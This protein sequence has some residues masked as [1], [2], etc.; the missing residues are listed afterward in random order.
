MLRQYACAGGEQHFF[1][2]PFFKKLSEILI[3]LMLIAPAGADDGHGGSFREMPLNFCHFGFPEYEVKCYFLVGSEGHSD[4]E[5]EGHGYRFKFKGRKAVGDIIGRSVSQNGWTIA[6]ISRI[7]PPPGSTASFASSS[8][9]VSEGGGTRNVQVNLSPAPQSAIT[10]TYTVGGSATRNTDYTTSGSVSVSSGATSVNIP[11]VITDD[12]DNENNETVLLT[13]NNGTGYTVGSPNSHTLTIQDNDPDPSGPTAS[14]AS[15]SGSVGEGGG[16][17]NVQ[18]N[19]SPAPQSTITVTYTVGG[20]ATRNTDYTTSG[21]VSVS[22]GATSVNIPVVITDDN[23]NENNETV[24][25]TLNNG[26]GYTVGSPNSHTLTI[27]DNDPDPSGPTASFASSSGS[28]GEGGGTRNVQVNLSPA[29]QST[30]TVTYTVGGSATHNTDYTT[31]GSVS[32]SS[33]ATSVNIPVVITDDNDNENNET[34]LLTLNNGTGYTVGSP[35]SHTLTIQD[36]DPDP[37]GPTASFASSS[38]SVSEG[39]GTRNVQVNLSPAPQ[40]AIIVTY[41]VG[42]SATRNTDYTTSGSVSVS[43]GA[44][45]VNIP[46]VITDDNDNENNET[47]LLTLNNGTGYTVGSPNSHTLTIQDNDND[48]DDNDNTNTDDNDNTN[49]DDNDNTNTDDNDNTNTDDNDNTNT[50]DNDNTNTDDNDNTNTD[51]NDNSPST[52]PDVTFVTP[53]VF[54]ASSSASVSEG[55]GTRNVQVNLSPA[56]QSAITVSYMIDGTATRGTDY[57]ISDFVS[58][59]SGATSVN[60]PVTITV[61]NIDENDET[62]VLMLTISSNYTLGNIE[63]H[64]LTIINDD[65]QPVLSIADVR[66]DE[67]DTAVFPVRLSSPSGKDVRVD[68]EISGGTATGDTDYTATSGT[69]HIPAGETQG[70]IEVKT[71]Q[72]M[73]DEDDKTIIVTLSNPVHATLEDGEAIGT[74]TDDD[75]QPVLSIADV[76]VD[77]GDT[78]VFPVQLS[79]PS[80]KD[81]RVDWEI[82]GGTATDDTDYTATS[83]T[84]H[85]PA[86]ETQG[87]VEVKTVQDM[88]DEDDKTIVVTLSNPVHATLEDGEAIGTITDDDVQPVLSIA[89]V[90]VDEGDTAVFPVRLS[91]PSGKDVRVDWEI[92]GGTATGDTDYTATS[93]TLHIPAGETQGTVEVKTVQDMLDEDDKTI[94]VTLSNPVHAT[95]EDGEAIGTIVDDDAQPALNI[96]DVRVDEGDTAVFP[97]RLSSPSGKDVR[98]DWEISG[99]TATGDTD[100]TATSGTLHIPAGETQGTVEVKTVQDELDEDDKTIV[101]TLSN[102][103]HATLEDGEAIG[104]IT[105]DDAQP[106]L[107]I[108]DVRVD[109]GDTAVFPVRL[110]S[111]SG[112]DVRVDWEISGGTATGDTDYTATSGTLHIPA[113]ETQGT[114]EVKTVQDMLDED[115]KTIVVTLSNP[116]H[117]TLEDGEAI[118]TIVDDDV[119]PVLNI[120]DVRVDEGDTAVFPVRLSS[121]SGKDVRVDWEI[122]GGTA[123]GDTDYTATSG[124][125]HIPAGETQGTVEVKTV[126]DEL[127]EDDKTIVVTLSNPVHATLEDGEAIGTITDD[128]VQPALSVA[129]TRVNEGDT[130]VFPVR[131][132]SPSGKDVRVDWEISGGTATGDTDYTA[133]SGTLHIPA[134][135]TQGTIE[136]KT[137]QDMLDE[138]DKTIVVT[139]SNPVHATLEDGEAIGTIVD[140][141]VQPALNIA[142]VRVDEGDT[143]VFPVRLSSPSGKDVRVDW[144][145]SGGT[146]TGDTDYT[147]TSGTLHIPAG[148]TQG[149]IEI[150]TVQDMLD[151]DDKTIVVTLSNPVHATLED[152]E[153][154]GTITDDDVQPALNIADVRVDEGDTAVFPV[155]LSSPS[156]KDVRVDWEISGGTATGD[157]DYTAT[158]GTLHIPAGET[159]GTVEVKT[160]QDMLDEDDKTIVVTLS[161]P[162]HATLEDGEAIG[163]ITDDDAEPILTVESVTVDEGATAVFRMYLSAESAKQVTANWT[164]DDAT[165]TAGADYMA[166]SG[167]LS[168]APGQTEQMVSVITIDDNEVETE[169]TFAVRLSN[170]S[171]AQ[172]GAE[173]VGRINDD[174]TQVVA[175]L[176]RATTAILPQVS[177]AMIHSKIEQITNCLEQAALGTS[178]TSDLS[179]LMLRYEMLGD[180]H[181]FWEVFDGIEFTGSLNDNAHS[182]RNVRNP[183]DITVCG[184]LD[185]RSLADVANSLEWDGSVHSFHLGSNVRLGKDFLAGLDI[186]QSVGNIDYQDGSD[187]VSGTWQLKMTSVNPY[188]SLYAQNGRH[189]WTTVGYGRGQLTIE[190]SDLSQVADASEV[191]AAIGA[192]LPLWSSGS[193]LGTCYDY[194]HLKG[195]A[196]WGRVAVENNGELIGDVEIA[197]EGLR[198][199]LESV[200][201][202]ALSSNSAIEWTTGAGMRYDN[203]AGGA[204]MEVSS[205]LGFVGSRLT[206]RS[207]ARML[208]LGGERKEWGVGMLVQLLP[209]SDGSGLSFE[210]APTWGETTNIA[211]R[212]WQE[213]LR[214]LSTGMGSNGSAM[215]AELG[216]GLVVREGRGLLTPFTALIWDSYAKTLQMG[217]R[218]RVAGLDLV[219]ST[220]HEHLNWVNDKNTSGIFLRALSR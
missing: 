202:R 19:L 60:I 12:N 32:V 194:L 110:S 212:M 167:T 135:E 211:D 94:V 217:L 62:M 205:S 165:A 101:V 47:V 113:G 79:S 84:L 105:D 34:V 57:T 149:T 182:V 49:T 80:G 10:V 100:Y 112:K 86:G 29:P 68:W 44:T 127:D 198:G 88:L 137:V 197:S 144:E 192:A 53:E 147:A 18:V 183:G 33:G 92:S 151:E 28:V 152:G 116:V 64:T 200:H 102:P 213:G 155:R 114:V 175:R 157:T 139:L 7:G 42:G 58:V 36:N 218:Y 121:P 131:L 14:F 46:V 169:E 70:T 73:L 185:W 119:Q 89:D 220:E 9:S 166:D 130:A 145:I 148:E 20:S 172:L 59:P 109:E 181:S 142:D 163:T 82:S 71:V 56:P 13:L 87:T 216:Y 21:S 118:G 63:K 108:A 124:T 199:M 156:G 74:I 162:V 3:L 72:D 50:D 90:R 123:T 97:V 45:S 104:T 193:I 55:G 122:S 219:L 5:I 99:G 83:G 15:S 184:G 16:T 128:D 120:A 207:T 195:D 85:I 27:Q 133:T 78:A 191:S 188:V 208:L 37:S 171:N 31:S 38:G 178:S 215:N 65:V 51:D 154:I 150:K 2:Y 189:V 168:F 107:S 115:D 95:L 186:S 138:D 17:R 173:G 4:S 158:S 177:A 23:D 201:R 8:G 76:R 179:A 140:D 176:T 117:A 196:Y 206:A 48:S 161:N 187:A 141:D 54:F 75:V 170:H 26:T 203:D 125:L 146:A 134:G 41:T 24:L 180:D 174:D 132:S 25:L 190:E 93:G 153:A 209:R 40:S 35:N 77:E 106:V 214:N 111:P 66:V 143:A 160:V 81:V 52:P 61:D 67:G 126:Q 96:A 91:S 11:V 30:I 39:G 164:T 6:R 98:V 22:S 129:D 69:L 210:M 159:Q 43:S 204:G 1:I 103:V 136:I